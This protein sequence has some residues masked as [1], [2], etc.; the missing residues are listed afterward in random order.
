MRENI[1]LWYKKESDVWMKVLIYNL[2]LN[3]GSTKSNTKI[4]QTGDRLC[5]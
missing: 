4:S 1:S 2:Y 5:L 3:A